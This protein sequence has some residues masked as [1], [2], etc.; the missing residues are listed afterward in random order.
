MHTLLNPTWLLQASSQLPH[1]A[2]AHLSPAA[3]AA[4]AQAAAAAAGRYVQLAASL[5]PLLPLLLGR[6][7]PRW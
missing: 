3:A 1:P 7:W 2:Q 4:A 6:C 5:L